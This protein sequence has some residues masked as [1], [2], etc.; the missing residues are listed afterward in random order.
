[1]AYKKFGEYL[2]QT[3]NALPSCG[4]EAIAFCIA[5]AVQVWHLLQ[6]GNEGKNYLVGYF[7]LLRSKISLVEKKKKQTGED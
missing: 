1:M 4:M 5:F 7:I 2:N 3:A 6:E